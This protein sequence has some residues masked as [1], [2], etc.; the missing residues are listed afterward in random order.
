MSQ[1][2]LQGVHPFQEVHRACVSASVYFSEAMPSAL[3]LA[4]SE[5]VIAPGWRHSQASALSSAS[6]MTI[7]FRVTQ[8]RPTLGISAPSLQDVGKMAAGRGMA[9]WEGK[10]AG[11]AS[12]RNTS[13]WKSASWVHLLWEASFLRFLLSL[14]YFNPVEEVDVVSSL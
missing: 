3:T 10:G 5:S 4:S 8:Q 2:R 14:V 12:S 6:S 9:A 11:V 1:N 7:I 13:E